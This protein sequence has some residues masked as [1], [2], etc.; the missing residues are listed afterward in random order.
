LIIGV[1]LVEAV[2]VMRELVFL[3]ASVAFDLAPPAR[4][5]PLM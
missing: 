4:A 2:M 3:G 5:Y 1:L